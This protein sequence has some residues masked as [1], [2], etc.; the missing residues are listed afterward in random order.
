MRVLAAFALVAAIG[1]AGWWWRN[2]ASAP[3]PAIT[4]TQATPASGPTA[5]PPNAAWAQLFEDLATEW[6]AKGEKR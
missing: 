3:E 2:G 6:D 4:E 1:A 5:A